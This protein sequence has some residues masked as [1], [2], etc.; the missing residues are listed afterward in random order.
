LAKL[1]VAIDGPAGSGKSTAARLVA[2][3]LGYVYI[4]T[5]ALY[6]AVALV[7]LGMH[8]G[9][10]EEEALA[11]LASTLEVDVRIQPGGALAYFIEG[12]DVTAKL[13]SPEVNRLV[14]YVAK[15]PAVRTTV[16]KKLQ[17]LAKR[18]GIVMDGRDI[19]TVV[20]PSAGVKIFLTADLA[21][22]VARRKKELSERGFSQSVNAVKEEVLRRDQEDS[23]RQLA[24]LKPAPDAYILDTTN[25]SPDQVVQAIVNL[26][27]QKKQHMQAGGVEP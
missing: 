6:R 27:K 21:T 17:R 24:P 7:A 22:R 3:E 18:G 11:K 13:R 5:G 10:N 25:L 16:T 26:V 9:G 19:G 8:I 14:P 1:Q 23:S 12:E 2:R 20:L 15:L 4:D